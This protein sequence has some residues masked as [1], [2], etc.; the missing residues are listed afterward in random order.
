M[1]KYSISIVGTPQRTKKSGLQAVRL[2]ISMDGKKIY[3]PTGIDYFPELIDKKTILPGAVPGKDFKLHREKIESLIQKI[4]SGIDS[5]K[6]N[7]VDEIGHF[8]TNRPIGNFQDFWRAWLMM[9]IKENKITHNTFKAQSESINRL[10]DFR[11]NVPFNDITLAFLEKYKDHLKNKG[12][13]RNTSWTSL[14][15]LRTAVNHAVKTGFIEQ[16][17]FKEFDMPKPKRRIE[18]LHE[19]EFQAVREYYQATTHPAHLEVLRAFIFSCYTGLRISDIQ[20]IRGKNIKAGHL[21]FEPIK[22]HRSET[23]E[24]TELE[25]PLHPFLSHIIEGVGRESLIF[26]KLPTEQKIN[27]NL[28]K[29]ATLCNIDKPISYHYARHTF[30]TRF[31]ASGGKIE[32]LRTLLGHESIETTMIYVHI[33]KK[34]AKDQINLIP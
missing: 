24:F 16:Y 26:Q 17:P 31:L 14:K 5:G 27:K 1:K 3:F 20:A 28:K 21:I 15:D 34:T 25:I 29:I 2:L 8:L 9:R 33:E 32:V 19:S 4:S 10:S 22:T 23:K 6:I 18:Y 30:A 13:E 12:Y 11:A 7:S